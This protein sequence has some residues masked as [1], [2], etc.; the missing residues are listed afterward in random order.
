MIDISL[1][2]QKIGR[3]IPKIKSF[4]KFRKCSPVAVGPRQRL[5][6]LRLRV[7]AI[8]L[9]IMLVTPCS[10]SLVLRDRGYSSKYQFA[11]GLS[12]YYTPRKQ[13]VGNFYGRYINGNGNNSPE[14]VK[15]YHLNIRSLFN[16]VME[17]KKITC[18]LKPHM[19][20]LSE[21]ELS[22]NLAGFN[23]DKL[24]VP[25]YQLLLYKSWELH[26]YARIAVYVRIMLSVG[27]IGICTTCKKCWK[28]RIHRMLIL[29]SNCDNSRI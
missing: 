16:K 18:D 28:F 27:I 29:Y 9:T 3:F 21:V 10:Y 26:G 20:G 7:L 24:K 2:R 13:L 25:G 1:Y 12:I 11:N 5:S 8:V 23:L 14:S 17:V 6:H 4:K 15:V 19:L 22:K